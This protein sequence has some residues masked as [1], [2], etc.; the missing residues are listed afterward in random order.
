MDKDKLKQWVALTVVG[1]LA[2]LAAGWFVVV[3]P[4]RGEAA[5]L[6]TQAQSEDSANATLGTQLAVLKAQARDLPKKQAELAAVAAKIPDNPALPSL[7]RALTAASD[8]ADV[9]FVS[10]T[11]GPPVATAPTGSTVVPVVSGVASVPA[12]GLMTIPVA[13]DVVGG[14]FEIEQYVASLEHLPRALRV[15]KL[16]MAPGANPVKPAANGQAAPVV[17]DG[18]LLTATVTSEVY[19]SRSAGGLL[20]APAP[21]ASRSA[22]P[23]A[24]ATK[25]A[26]T[27]TQEPR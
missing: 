25:A 13:I 26:P 24:K 27:A 8:K 11:P 12:G 5:D 1:V 18:R 20:P 14:Y 4:K 23:S 3:S 9:E 21:V 16:E 19:M 22:T 7:I 10:L 15:T 6:R 17:P 2:V